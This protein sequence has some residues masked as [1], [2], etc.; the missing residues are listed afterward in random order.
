MFECPDDIS[1]AWKPTF[2]QGCNDLVVVYY[3]MAAFNITTDLLIFLLPLPTV[4]A[5]QVNSRKRAAL[6]M[7]FSVGGLAVIAS[8]VRINALYKYQDAAQNA[9][10]VPCA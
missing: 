3:S 7:I 8:I 2:P 10:D 4:L 5:L 6:L 1:R 9:G